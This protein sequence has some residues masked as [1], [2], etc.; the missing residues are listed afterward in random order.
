MNIKNVLDTLW[1]FTL[2]LLYVFYFILS[3]QQNYSKIILYL[4]FNPW[5]INET[6]SQ[7]LNVKL[8][9]FDFIPL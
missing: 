3:V 9:L 2:K 4:Y 5:I 6:P 8:D 1:N 7:R